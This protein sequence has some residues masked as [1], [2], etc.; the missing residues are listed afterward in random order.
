MTII[1]SAL[2][3]LFLLYATTSAHASREQKCEQSVENY[4]GTFLKK[5][6][7]P[8]SYANREVDGSRVITSA[9]KS[10]PD[11]NK[12]KIVAIAYEDSSAINAEEQDAKQFALAMVNSITGEVLGIYNPK[13]AIIE[14]GSSFD[15][16]TG[17][18][19]LAKGVRAFGLVT[20]TYRPNCGDG[21]NSGDFYLYVLNGK[22]IKPI[23]SGFSKNY[24]RI[25]Q[26]GPSC[27]PAEGTVTEEASITI[28]VE[29]SKTNGYS[30]L[31]ITA[32]NPERKNLIQIIKF[33]GENYMLDG[34]NNAFEKW[35]YRN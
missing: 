3:A 30:D 9:C 25:V 5:N 6:F 31:S 7:I 12:I 24:W 14:N 16:D 1:R 8:N 10:L 26:G 11:D 20:T 35:W 33:N 2:I 28:G 22:R 15:I 29:K 13:E 4:L 17:K 18:Y 27:A 34:W 23:L 32:S 19:I 21:G